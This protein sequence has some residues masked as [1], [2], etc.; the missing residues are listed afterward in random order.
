MPAF[1]LHQV[2]STLPGRARAEDEGPGATEAIG[3][4]PARLI[5]AQIRLDRTTVSR[6]MI[7]IGF[8]AE[9]PA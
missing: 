5:D 3:S 2:R 6:T 1:L 8:F 4:D 9:I 7:D